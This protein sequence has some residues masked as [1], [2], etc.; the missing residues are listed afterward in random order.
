MLVLKISHLSNAENKQKRH[1]EKLQKGGKHFIN[2]AVFLNGKEIR[3]DEY[4]EYLSRHA[5][6]HFI[7]YTCHQG[8]L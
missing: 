1:A 5:S 4:V 7:I 6:D 8:R 2:L 3:I